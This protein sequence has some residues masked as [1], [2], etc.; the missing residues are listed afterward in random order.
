MDRPYDSIP[1]Q[2]K[3]LGKDL[4]EEPTTNVRAQPA[5]KPTSDDST[6]GGIIQCSFNAAAGRY[7]IRRWP[8][9]SKVSPG[10]GYEELRRV[11]EGSPPDE[12]L[13]ALPDAPHFVVLENS[14]TGE[15]FFDKE[16]DLS[17]NWTGD[18]QFDQVT[19]FDTEEAAENYASERQDRS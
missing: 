11:P 1:R 14:E 7:R 9:E 17:G 10:E 4:D 6:S 19:V 8:D 3:H 18:G 5:A 2:G 13:E 12:I 15:V 16:S